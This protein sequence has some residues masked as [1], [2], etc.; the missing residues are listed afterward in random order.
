MID[1]VIVGAGP[2]G[3]SA[4]IAAAENGLT[5]RIVDEFVKPGGRLLGQL[6]EEPDGQWWN[7]IAEAAKL[8]ERASQLGV[9]VTCGVSVFDLRQRPEGWCVYTNQGTIKARSLLLATGATESP[10]PVPGWTLPGVMSIGAA[11]VMSTVHRVKPGKHGVII[12][13]NVLSIAIAR[14]LQLCWVDLKG[15]LM[16]QSNLA[17][18]EHANPQKVMEVLLRLS[19]LSPSP[20]LRFGGKLVSPELGLR[21]FPKTGFKMWGIP[22]QVRKAVTE[23]IGEKQVEGVRIADITRNGEIISGTEKEVPVDFVCIAGGLAPLAELAAIA[24]CTF[25]HFPELGGYVPLHSAYM[26]TE[27]DGLYVAGNITGIESAKVAMAQGTVAGLAITSKLK[28]KA[29]FI[30]QKLEKAVQNVEET[31]KNALIQFHPGIAEARTKQRSQFGSLSL[32]V[33]RS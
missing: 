6:H 1:L 30:E 15:I 27:L 8:N 26:Q 10:I 14:E 25:R 20:L 2:A 24:G 16:P 9:K 33:V 13:V 23:I 19:S 4:A 17:T 21:F 32:K 3:L 12:G 31:R 11:Q 5:V 7:G 22:I 29:A 28:N 18:G